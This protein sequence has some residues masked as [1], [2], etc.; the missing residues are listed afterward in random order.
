MA[1]LNGTN[2]TITQGGTAIANATDC[3]ISFTRELVDITTKDSGGYREVIPR[4]R[5]ATFSVSGFVEMNETNGSQALS[6]ACEGGTSLTVVFDMDDGTNTETYSCSA[7]C[8]SI[9]MSGGIEDAAQ[10]SAT[11]ESTGTITRATT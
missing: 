8:S 7:L 4:Q 5:Q 3:S 6:A 9:E 1:I 10:F 2:V 11:L